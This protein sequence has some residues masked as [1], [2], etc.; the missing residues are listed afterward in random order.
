MSISA[1]SPTRSLR[2]YDRNGQRHLLVGGESHRP[3]VSPDERVHWDRLE[4]WA[5]EHFALGP[6]DYR[7]SAQDYTPVDGIPYAGRLT[8][9]SGHLWTATGFRKWGMTNGT[10]A[11]MIIAGEL[12][13]QRHPWA[14]TFNAQRLS[15]S[16]SALSFIDE[17]AR[18]GFHF[19]ADRLRLPA[20]RA[21]DDLEDG[22][23]A[24]V[25]I[26]G[27][28]VA[29]SRQG[30]R[31]CAVSPVC[32]HLGC[33]VAWNRAERSWD[34]PCHGSRFDAQGSVIHGPATRDL[35]ARPLPGQ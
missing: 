13:G 20:R 7:W 34:C 16:A 15:V 5:R 31:L 1:G 22:D 23:G 26:D 10:A 8:P 24:V 32:T 11:A 17:N 33:H 30:D 2:I 28:A 25:R 6:V 12:S 27:R 29:V 21:V 9:L 19:F 3:G 35:K 18:V 14:A 4:Q